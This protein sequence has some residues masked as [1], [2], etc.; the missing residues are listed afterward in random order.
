MVVALAGCGTDASTSTREPTREP[1]PV[2][3]PAGDLT[4]AL[5]S[6]LHVGERSFDVAPEVI[7]SLDW[8]PYGVYLELT[9]DP[10][11]GIARTVFFDGESTAEFGGD[12]ISRVVT[13]A[14]GGLAAWIDFEG[15][16][17][18]AG[19][20]AEVVVV[21]T[22]TGDEIFTTSEG[23]GGDAGDDLGDRYEELPPS[24]TMFDGD[25]LIWVNAEGSGDTLRSDV[26]TGDTER[27]SAVDRQ[28][29][30]TTSGFEFSSP[31]GAYDVDA[32]TT[33]KLRIAPRQPDFG[34]RW[35]TAGQ[36]L[37][38]HTLLVLGQDRYR[39]SYDPTVP[40]TIPG[41]LLSCDL[42]EGRCDGL[43]PIDGARD[44]VFPGVDSAY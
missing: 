12:H 32:S 10:I 35:Q 40:D 13:S 20:V 25:D 23:M 8:T 17:R 33:G 24:V 37:D 14:D 19:R 21:D 28:R 43:V 30:R 4:Y 1:R 5:R 36:W 18:P 9:S 2:V 41:E 11:E 38:D 44:V 3:F 34:Y 42:A 29:L 7:T 39:F 27:L 6:T 15:P 22:E 31:D 26:R 16:R